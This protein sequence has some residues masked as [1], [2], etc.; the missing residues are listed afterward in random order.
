MFSIRL[1]RRLG[2]AACAALFGIGPAL[3][4]PDAVPVQRL[5]AMAVH[6][7][8]AGDAGR[9]IALYR[10]AIDAGPE[11]ARDRVTGGRVVAGLLH[12]YERA[13]R[14]DEAIAFL[15]TDP[16]A[17]SA[18]SAWRPL[19]CQL[20]LKRAML[21]RA[22]PACT[23]AQAEEARR[24]AA[25]APSQLALAGRALAIR[26]SL[27]EIAGAVP[28]ASAV[29]FRQ[30]DQTGNTAFS[31]PGES[32][33]R[34]LS[35]HALLARL[36]AQ[37]GDRAAL[38]RYYE[39]AFTPYAQDLERRLAPL[40]PATGFQPL[41]DDYALLGAL[42]GGAGLETQALQAV[43]AALALNATRTRFIASQY[44]PALLAG[45]LATRRAKLG[46]LSALVLRSPEPQAQLLTVLAGELLQAKGALSELLA[47]RHAHVMRSGA[48]ELVALYD[49]AE[50]AAAN[51]DEAAWRTAVLRLDASIPDWLPATL[52]EDGAAFHDRV[53]ARLGDE[54]L[55]SVLRQ[56]PFDLATQAYGAPHYLALCLR[57][58]ALQ[59]RDLGPADDIDLLVQRYRQEAAAA[60]GGAADDA[61]LRALARQLYARILAPVLGERLPAG[62]YVADLDGLL[63][64]LPLE[65]LVD[66]SD[67]YLLDA[68]S[69]RHVGSARALLR[70]AAPAPA[71]ALGKAVLLVDPAFAA[72]PKPRAA[73]ANAMRR[74]LA[75]AAGRFTPLPD[76]RDEGRQVARALRRMGLQ[77]TLL[78]GRQADAAALA[79][80]KS[81][82]ILHIATHGFFFEQ[83]APARPGLYSVAAASGGMAGGIAL[84]GSNGPSEGADGLVFISQFRTLDLVGTELVVLSAC[85]TGV[86]SVR[87]GEGLNSLRQALELAGSRAQVTALWKVPSAAT[88]RLMALFYERM[89]QGAPA[90][91]ALRQAKLALRA[92]HP[93]P[94]FWAGFTL[95]GQER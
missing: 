90:A 92:T 7:A 43:R 64:L 35:P 36:H 23:E 82:R 4:A 30:A 17:R 95:S 41:E 71:G 39:E 77:P 9:A 3:G 94:L 10:Q 81:P 42:L 20:Y 80:L 85:D 69:W 1:L 34:T 13:G 89:A 59:V 76:T 45:T 51:G 50:T 93:H 88:A 14:S 53:A 72:A 61:R 5:L 86:G 62:R 44:N 24:V 91:Q 46:L 47:L 78:A 31:R 73:P 84:A 57:A 18:G 87:S 68:G 79:A 11:L 74:T 75:A 28:D 22:A 29:V 40:A 33:L 52:F 32:F 55:V 6:E 25:Q 48:P 83:E 60:Q 37:Q 16:F 63:N 15:E 54:T 58:G 2:A 67:R 27:F 70:E 21:D 56:A 12:A 19:L 49:A 38:L 8:M 66:G 65:A 26:Q